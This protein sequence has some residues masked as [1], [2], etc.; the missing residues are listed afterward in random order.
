MG[1][2]DIVRLL[3]GSAELIDMQDL[4]RRVLDRGRRNDEIKALLI[5]AGAS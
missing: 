3:T 2:T 5:A 1:W 4:G